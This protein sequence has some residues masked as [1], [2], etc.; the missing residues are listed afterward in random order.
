M[1]A[2]QT[3]QGPGSWP[4]V[5]IILLNWHGWR[6][7]L[8]CLASL[9]K[10]DY[11]DHRVL[12]VDNGSTD[13]SV[14]RIRKAYSEA[15]LLL[16]PSW[17]ESFPLFPLE[18]MAC[19]TPVVTTPYG[20]EDYIIHLENAF[21]IPPRDPE[22]MAEAILTLYQDQELTSRLKMNAPRD[23]KRFTWEQSVQRMASLIGLETPLAESPSG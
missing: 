21:V 3:K 2:S 8:A 4:S 13:D 17:Y 20:V 12:V 10:L 15:H 6:D 11:P 18:A 19:G 7:T 22:A 1:G 16:A 9:E 5:A 23:A 14:E